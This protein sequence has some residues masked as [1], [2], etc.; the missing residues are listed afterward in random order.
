MS[1]LIWITVALFPLSE[2][3]LLILKRT[4]RRTSQEADKGTLLAF[5]LTIIASLGLAIG[6]QWL[7]FADYTLMIPVYLLLGP[8]LI[9]VGLIL[10]WVAILSLGSMFTVNVAIQASHKL[11]DKGVYRYVRH[12]SYTGLLLAFMG[13]GFFFSNWLSLLSLMFPIYFAVAWRIKQEE[14]ALLTA[15][16][17]SY[18]AYCQRTKKLIPFIL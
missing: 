7:V 9:L 5:W 6:C 8:G 14:K 15:F 18:K 11:V 1:V 12:P 10:R 4:N 2:I 3:T 17:D 16:G 13:L